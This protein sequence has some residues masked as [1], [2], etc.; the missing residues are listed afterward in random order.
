MFEVCFPMPCTRGHVEA[1]EWHDPSATQTSRTQQ[2]L[3]E[4]IAGFRAHEI[5][6]AMPANAVPPAFG[7][8]VQCTIK[9]SSAQTLPFSARIRDCSSNRSMGSNSWATSLIVFLRFVGGG[10]GV[11]I[12]VGI[13][14]SS[15][16]RC[17]GG[18]MCGCRWCCDT[19]W[20]CAYT[21]VAT[22]TASS[23]SAIQGRTPACFLRLRA[24]AIFGA[25][26]PSAA[27]SPS[28]SPL[29]IDGVF[30]NRFINRCVAPSRRHGPQWHD[31]VS[32]SHAIFIK[33]RTMADTSCPSARNE[34]TPQSTWNGQWRPLWALA[35]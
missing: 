35:V 24:A 26:L 8:C 14:G 27:C 6:L 10:A 7:T 12:I 17:R 1:V 21:K 28:R 16:C 23:K 11:A 32:K 22:T 19:T 2:G 34:R 4:A 30:I 29:S 15:S 18:G 20:T 5:F 13:T 25:G 33:P 3:E 31:D 9:T